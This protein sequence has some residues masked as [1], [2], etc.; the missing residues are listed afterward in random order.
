MSANM[1]YSKGKAAFVSFQQPA[2]WDIGKQY[3]TADKITVEKALEDGGLSFIV[4]KAANTHNIL[5]DAGRL[6]TSIVS[7]DSFFTYRTDTNAVLGSRLGKVYKPYQNT[8]ALAVVDDLLKSGKVTIETAGVVD[9]GRRVFI[10][11]KFAEPMKVGNKDEIFQYLLLCNSHDG[12]M[13][14]TALVTNVRVVCANTLAAALAGAKGEYKIRHTTNA[15]D[16]VKESFAIMGLL[17]DNRKITSAAYNA[18]QHNT[19][20]KQEFFDYVGN[21]FIDSKDIA[22][23]QKGNKD[24]LTNKKKDV[25]GDVFI[26][27]ETGPGQHMALGNHYNMWFAYN[28]VTGYLTSKNYKSADDR[29]ESL[30]F[31]DSA[32]KIKAAGELAL[33][34]HNIMPL[35]ANASAGLGLN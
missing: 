10:C 30:M 2:W 19:L 20:T 35:R 28:A 12:T 31:G 24:V 32:D 11:L 5:D 1:D 27:S 7:P 21:I 29:F 13:S 15:Q 22:E 14:I 33:A 16:R 17:E 34:P 3:T 18:M 6:I 8:D 26:Y 25:L 23:L 4:K 9:G